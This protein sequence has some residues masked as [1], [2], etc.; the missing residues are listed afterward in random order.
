MHHEVGV[1]DLFKGGSEGLDQVVRKVPHEADRV[2]DGAVPT[3]RQVQPSHGR[4]QGREQRVLDEHARAGE[5]IEQARLSRVGVA[6]EGYRGCPRALARGA[7]RAAYALHLLELAAQDR[8]LVTD[9][10]AVGLDLGLARSARTDTTG[11]ASRATTG[12]ATQGLTPATQTRQEV[13]H[14]GQRHLRATG[15]AAGVLSEDVED[16]PGAIDDL[17]LDDVLQVAQLPRAQLAI[18]DDRVSA[19]Q[20]D[21]FAE[22]ARFARPDVRRRIGPITPL[23]D[24][25]EDQCPRGLREGGQLAQA[26]LRLLGGALGPHSDE[27]DLLQA[28]LAVFDLGDVLEFGGQ[29]HHTAKRLT[30]LKVEVTDRRAV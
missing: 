27:H 21:E 9:T 1:G 10:A 19:C 14:L 7:L 29:A 16:E 28:H 8:H 22:F 12:L 30:V 18:A 17:D 24:A 6:G 11:R 5:S 20:H 23:D 26:A 15:L 25:I 3:A 13:L 2:R 4:I